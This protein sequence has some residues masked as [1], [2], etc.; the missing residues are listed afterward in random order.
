MMCIVHSAAQA[1]VCNSW[2]YYSIA[3]LL[4]IRP[5]YRSLA[6]ATY[7]YLLVAAHML[8]LPFIWYLVTLQLRVLMNDASIYSKSDT[9]ALKEHHL[10]SMV[11]FIAGA[12][13]HP[14]ESPRIITVILHIIYDDSSP[15]ALIHRRYLPDE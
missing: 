5:C 11:L 12:S 10:L 13:Q 2:Q 8:C 14:S 4:L 3:H 15:L 9:T 1:L 6:S 7:H